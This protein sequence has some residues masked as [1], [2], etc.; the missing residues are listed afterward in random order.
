MEPLDEGQ[1]R[2]LA[3]LRSQG[4]SWTRMEPARRVAL[5]TVIAIV[6]GAVGAALAAA[7]EGPWPWVGL[8]A[9]SVTLL[10][11]LPNVIAPERTLERSVRATV[12]TAE[13][14]TRG[15]RNRNWP[16]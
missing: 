9:A 5:A 11:L 13:S 10:V 6:T 3:F 7:A 8:G 1:R 4:S 15:D 2:E 12:P 16:G 14:M